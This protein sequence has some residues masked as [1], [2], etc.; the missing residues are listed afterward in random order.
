M[1]AELMDF[2]VMLQE[3]LCK[4]EL[5]LETLQNELESLRAM[6]PTLDLRN[7]GM[8]GNVQIWIPSAFLKGNLI[9]SMVVCRRAIRI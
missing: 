7:D 9:E 2:N 3:N 5:M 1:H 8:S 4:K 6:N